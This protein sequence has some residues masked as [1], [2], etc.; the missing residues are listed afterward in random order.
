MVH[1]LRQ[2]II[3]ETLK[4]TKTL[5]WN[6]EEGSWLKYQH[7]EPELV[8][9]DHFS[10]CPLRWKITKNVTHDVSF[11]YQRCVGKRPDWIMLS[12]LCNVWYASTFNP[13][14]AIKGDKP[15]APRTRRLTFEFYEPD[16]NIIF[17]LPRWQCVYFMFYAAWQDAVMYLASSNSQLLDKKFNFRC[18]TTS[19]S[20]STVIG[21][22][23]CCTEGQNYWRCECIL[24]FTSK[25]K[26]L[27]EIFTW[28]ACTD[29]ANAWRPRRGLSWNRGR[30]RSQKVV[31]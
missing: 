1:Q 6:N 12:L 28:S 24:T 10:N 11:G 29:V 20:Q 31:N 27:S 9:T 3:I 13:G 16:Q 4:S 22:P 18:N 17:S 5:W 26:R 7:C 14:H 15:N 30:L 19:V 8:L 2:Y 23:K 25:S 21:V